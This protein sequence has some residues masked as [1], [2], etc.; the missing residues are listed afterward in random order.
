[1]SE[2]KQALSDYQ[3]DPEAA[4]EKHGANFY[5]GVEETMGRGWLERN[6]ERDEE[7][8]EVGVSVSET[9]SQVESS[10]A[11]DSEAVQ[12]AVEVNTEEH[13]EGA[14][15][16]D[17][18]AMLSSIDT[19]A[20]AALAGTEIAEEKLPEDHEPSPPNADIASNAQQE[21]QDITPSMS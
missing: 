7:Q 17:Y 9:A 13:V 19:T 16:T 3:D 12:Q 20:T 21:S 18:A 1:M 5:E 4:V 10:Q 8:Q 15:V 14:K 11:L 2:R 6:R